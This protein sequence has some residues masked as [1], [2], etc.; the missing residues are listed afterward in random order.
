MSCVGVFCPDT[1]VQNKQDYNYS[2]CIWILHVN[3]PQIAARS[4]QTEYMTSHL[5]L[6]V[7]WSKKVTFCNM[8]VFWLVA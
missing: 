7:V 1:C 6:V 5:N 8:T 3:G 4:L 2:N